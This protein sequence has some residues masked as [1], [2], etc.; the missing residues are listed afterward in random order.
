MNEK[1]ENHLAHSM[2][3]SFIYLFWVTA[4]KPNIMWKVDPLQDYK[5]ISKCVVSWVTSLR[6]SECVAF[7]S[8]I[9]INWV[10]IEP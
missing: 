5:T 10:Q 8:Q 3:F 2:F 6:S 7:D 4:A 1:E 9:G